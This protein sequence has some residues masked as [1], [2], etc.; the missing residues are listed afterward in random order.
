MNVN[1][2][3]FSNQSN[4]TDAFI[5]NTHVNEMFSTYTQCN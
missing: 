3:T 4:D 1:M 5:V 2:D